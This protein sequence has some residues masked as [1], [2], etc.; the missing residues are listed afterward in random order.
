MTEHNCKIVVK[1]SD[2]ILLEFN[3][4]AAFQWKIDIFQKNTQI[5]IQ[6]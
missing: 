2:S 6:L 3:F 1:Y 4:K 5:H